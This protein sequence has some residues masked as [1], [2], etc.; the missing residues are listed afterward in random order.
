MSKLELYVDGASKGNPGEAG[1]GV[2]LYRNGSVVKTISS[3]IGKATNN[4][5]EYTALIYGLEAA[6]ALQADDVVVYTDS[7]LMARQLKG[8][9]KIRS[10]G[11]KDLYQQ[12]LRL[13][14]RFKKYAV[15]HIPRERN[16]EADRLAT[17]AVKEYARNGLIKEESVSVG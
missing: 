8:E 12:S 6:H 1:V 10:A 14:M 7:E 5:A 17:A 9:Y 16:K 4:V 15:C 3:Y 11:L 2:V 13:L